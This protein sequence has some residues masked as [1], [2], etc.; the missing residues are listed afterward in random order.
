MLFTNFEDILIGVVHGTI[1]REWKEV[2]GIEEVL[3]AN[4]NKMKKLMR[5]S[6]EKNFKIKMEEDFKK[7]NREDAAY[8]NAMLKYCLP[9][10]CQDKKISKDQAAKEAKALQ[11]INIKNDKEKFKCKLKEFLKKYVLRTGSQTYIPSLP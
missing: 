8:Q 10:L 5:E 7:F 6:Y 1:T 2:G 9:D 11:D 3:C 4:D